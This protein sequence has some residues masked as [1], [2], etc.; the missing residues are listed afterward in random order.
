MLHAPSASMTAQVFL[1]VLIAGTAWR[2]ISYHLV[3]S[4]N[5]NIAHVGKAMAFQF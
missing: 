5:D 3:A 4:N 2:L 1:M